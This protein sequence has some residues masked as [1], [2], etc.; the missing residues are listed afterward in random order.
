[1]FIVIVL[2][3]QEPNANE[4]KFVM[5]FTRKTGINRQHPKVVVE[6]FEIL[7]TFNTNTTALP[8]SMFIEFW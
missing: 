1:M 6:L 3:V 8:P 5:P 2:K 7:I 4:I